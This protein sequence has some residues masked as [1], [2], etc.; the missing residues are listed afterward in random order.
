MVAEPLIDD[1]FR[2]LQ[3]RHEKEEF[4]E[5]N[6]AIGVGVCVLHDFGNLILMSVNVKLAGNDFRMIVG[7]DCSVEVGICH[8]KAPVRVL[9][10][11]E[12]FKDLFW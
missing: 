8:H 6:I 3:H 10:R 7:R 1:R 2:H 4:G 12:R 9:F 11:S 5:L